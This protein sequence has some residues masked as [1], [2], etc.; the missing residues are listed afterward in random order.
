MS[1]SAS[2]IVLS[3]SEVPGMTWSDDWGAPVCR[4]F[5]APY[6]NGDCPI[7]SIPLLTEMRDADTNEL[8]GFQGGI[9][10]EGGEYLA[11]FDFNDV[12]G[13]VLVN[14]PPT[15]GLIE[16]GKQ[17]EVLIT[18]ESEDNGGDMPNE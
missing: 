14:C 12:D 13:Y 6:K 18:Y 5:N 2:A 4:I 7:I 11:T 10:D 9:M 8:F 16:A 17:Y 3:N 1:D 15:D